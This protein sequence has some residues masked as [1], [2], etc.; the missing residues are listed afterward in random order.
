MG[1]SQPSCRLRAP[2]EMRSLVIPGG[3][4]H[5]TE[6]VPRGLLLCAV[7]AHPRR[8]AGVERILVSG[9]HHAG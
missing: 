3:S 4:S 8:V 7:E 6:L 2:T 1:R 5:D 9:V